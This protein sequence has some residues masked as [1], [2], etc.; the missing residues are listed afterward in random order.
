LKTI[1]NVTIYKCDFC[2]KEL[3]RK[4]AMINHELQC[5]NNPINQRPCLDGCKYLLRKP[6]VL[7]IGIDDYYS[8]EPTTRTYNGF[9]CS[10]KE[11]YLLHPKIEHKN[12]FIKSEVIYNEQDVEISQE[13]MPL[14]CG[15]Y[16]NP[17]EF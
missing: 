1:E 11:I 2:K 3:K 4:H 16:K 17:F 5:N 9:Y 10:L 7:D 14:E 8:G 12:K 6:I 13:S 15:E